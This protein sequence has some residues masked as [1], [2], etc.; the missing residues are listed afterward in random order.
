MPKTCVTGTPI[1]SG[2][3]VKF[4]ALK[5]TDEPLKAD[6]VFTGTTGSD[7]IQCTLTGRLIGQDYYFFAAVDISG[8]FDLRGKTMQQLITAVSRGEVLF[9]QSKEPPELNN[10]KLYTL[11]DGITIDNFEFIDANSSAS[12]IVFTVPNKYK[13]PSSVEGADDGE[14]FDIPVGK[15]IKFYAITYN[16][17]HSANE[18]QTTIKINGELIHEDTTGG[19]NIYTAELPDHLINQ[20]RYFLALIVLSETEDY[21]LPR[22]TVENLKSAMLAGKVL[23]GRHLISGQGDIELVK[24]VSGINEIDNFEFQGQEP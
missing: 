22:M 13:G 5:S 6:G 19:S 2:K 11:T 16:A 7:N 10:N 3:A 14:E 18:A 1:P 4:Y 9:G 17:Y 21:D 8:S 20:E 15:R 12:S 24:I 23:Y